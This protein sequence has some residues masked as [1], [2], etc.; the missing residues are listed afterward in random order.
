[1]P[2][3]VQPPGPDGR[4]RPAGGEDRPDDLVQREQQVLDDLALE[5]CPS[6]APD[7]G[8]PELDR[9]VSRRDHGRR[10]VAESRRRDGGQEH[11]ARPRPRNESSASRNDTAASEPSASRSRAARGG[12]TTAT[13][14][15]PRATPARRN[16]ATPA[17][18]SSSFE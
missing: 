16:G 10:A 18:N 13:T 6:R 12:L 15:S 3:A 5:T 17:T 11:G 7:D 1:E 4:A 2:F 8:P 14:A 9:L